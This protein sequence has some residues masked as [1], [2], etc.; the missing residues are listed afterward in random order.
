MTSPQVV[1]DR[2]ALRSNTT[3][4]RME[5]GPSP[6]PSKSELSLVSTPQERA[7]EKKAGDLLRRLRVDFAGP[8]TDGAGELIGRLGTGDSIFLR[9]HEGWD[10]GDALVGGFLCLAGDQRDILIGGK[11]LADVVGI[12][13]DISRGLHQHVDVGQVAAIAKIQ[14]HQALLYLG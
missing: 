11:T 3:L 10:T 5:R 6:R 14:F 9:K 8:L 13:A 2:W 7:R 1:V 4:R 12:K